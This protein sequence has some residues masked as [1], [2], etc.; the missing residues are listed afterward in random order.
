MKKRITSESSGSSLLSQFPEV[1][2][3]IIIMVAIIVVVFII[4][5]NTTYLPC[6]FMN[7]TGEVD[8]SFSLCSDFSLKTIRSNSP[9]LRIRHPTFSLWFLIEQT[10][11]NRSPELRV[12][13]RI[14]SLRLLIKNNT[15]IAPGTSGSASLPFPYDFLV[16]ALR[17]LVHGPPDPPAYLFLTIAYQKQ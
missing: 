9:D 17:K 3:H 10:W 1:M 11:G 5:L 12:R 16:Q 13:Q 7:F 14:F 15:K 6:R 4:V 8:E 2:F